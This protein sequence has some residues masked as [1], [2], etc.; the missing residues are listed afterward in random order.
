MELSQYFVYVDI[1][2]TVIKLG[3]SELTKTLPPHG[4]LYVNTV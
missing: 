4:M 1:H 2:I 3:H